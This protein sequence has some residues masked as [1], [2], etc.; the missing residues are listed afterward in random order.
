MNTPDIGSRKLS[1]NQLNSILPTTPPETIVLFNDASRKSLWNRI[2][3]WLFPYLKESEKLTRQLIEAKVKQEENIALKTEAEINLLKIKEVREYNSIINE[4]FSD[5]KLPEEAKVLKL[6]KL[7]E[8]NNDSI[9]ILKSAK[10][11]IV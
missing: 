11:S 8:N 7:L 10:K 1:V 4:I 2:K 5:D 9:A 3:Y 6:A